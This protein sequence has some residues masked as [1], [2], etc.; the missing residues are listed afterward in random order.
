MSGK[1]KITIVGGSLNGI[2]F[3]FP[4]DREVLIGRSSKADVRLSAS[5]SDV[6]GK[7]LKLVL[8]EGVPMA[9][10]VTS[11]SHATFHQGS[12][13]PPDGGSVVVAAHDAIELGASRS[14]RIRFDAV[15]AEEPTFVNDGDAP[16]TAA[17]RWTESVS[18][19]APTAV[20]EESA[21]TSQVRDDA[22]F[23][24][25]V[26]ETFATRMPS[27]PSAGIGA[28]LDDET[29]LVSGGED[30]FMS[31]NEE[32]TTNGVNDDEES[33]KTRDMETRAGAMEEIMAMK[34]GLERRRRRRHVVV[35]FGFLLVVG[36]LAGLWFASRKNN[37]TST[38]DFPLDAEGRPDMAT[39]SVKDEQGR[40]LV[41]VDYPRDNGMS[42]TESTDGGGVIVVS[43]MGRD[44]DVPFFLQLETVSR[45]EEL[46]KDLL[47]SVRTWISSAEES[48]AGYVFD[49]KV[50]DELKYQFFE[51]VFPGC[52][53]S[54]SLYGV[55]FVT[56]DYKR[57]WSDSEKTLWHGVLLYFR[58]GDTVFI[59]RR[60][61]PESYWVRGGYRIEQDPNIAI[62]SNFIDSYWESPGL[63]GL[64]VDRKTSELME[65]VRGLLAKE[66]ASDWRYAKKE[67][68]AVLVKTWRID[69]KARDL[70]EGCLRQFRDILRTYYYSKYNA[71]DTARENR[72]EKR[73]SR[74]RRDA[75]MVFDDP[76]ERYY[77][78]VAN[79]EVW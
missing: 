26:S 16:S 1:W 18:A 57:T 63:E 59:H 14:I 38:M 42:V 61:I 45:A 35:M 50:K 31:P 54:K 3:S 44:R 27:A 34:E 2:D 11:R 9:V 17:T 68:D 12:E 20:I 23:A 40:V 53:E 65:S 47:A 10:N 56:F 69:P 66:R 29:V 32:T 13:V 30:V 15:P 64:P 60:E 8:S 55:K 70:A 7:H 39:Y 58:K 5:E 21:V 72:D 74:I 41:K 79:G 46:E 67:I 49:I 51:D 62:Y 4:S 37:E 75:A 78:L 43:S 28:L 19:S 25:R 77:H 71:F 76:D 36:M 52:C 24:T 22:T 6:S 33:G 48:G 73:M